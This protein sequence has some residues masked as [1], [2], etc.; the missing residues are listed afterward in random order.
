MQDKVAT[1]DVTWCTSLM[2]SYFCIMKRKTPIG[3]LYMVLVIHPWT[4]DIY[5]S[6]IDSVSCGTVKKQPPS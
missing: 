6:L 2:G 5:D 3:I 4:Q 1:T